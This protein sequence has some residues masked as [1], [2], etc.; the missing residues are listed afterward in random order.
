[1]RAD[2]MAVF[3]IVLSK[4]DLGLKAADEQGFLKRS[5]VK[6]VVAFYLARH[7]LLWGGIGEVVQ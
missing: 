2:M 5:I 7:P 1:M 3:F 4:E 6:K